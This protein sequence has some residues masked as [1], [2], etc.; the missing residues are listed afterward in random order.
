MKKQLKNLTCL[1]LLICSL[2]GQD[3]T[4][5]QPNDQTTFELLS[6]A[7]SQEFFWT[8][9]SINMEDL[10]KLYILDHGVALDL[11]ESFAIKS[12]PVEIIQ[13]NQISAIGNQ[14]LIQVHTLNVNK[15]K[16]L[17]RLYLTY[18]QTGEE[19]SSNSEFLYE[20]NGTNWVLTTK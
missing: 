17:V 5:Q 12:I 4:A 10:S 14:P 2:Y 16:A 11:P 3:V 9:S 6:H 15:D 18:K 7:I 1:L 13:K 19:K 20:H 8:A